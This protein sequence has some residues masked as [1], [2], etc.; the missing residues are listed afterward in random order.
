MLTERRNV[1]DIAQGPTD[2]R[3]KFR[4][5]GLSPGVYSVTARGNAPG[6]PRETLTVQVEVVMKVSNSMD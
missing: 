4:L 3:G 2:D 6:L 1:R 5:A